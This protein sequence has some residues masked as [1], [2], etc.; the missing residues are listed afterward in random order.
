M[1]FEKCREI[2]LRESELVQEIVG[3]QNLIREAVI[4]RDWTD[5]EGHFDALNRIKTELI[6]LEGER[7]GFLSNSTRFYA[8]AARF[9]HEQR[10]ELTDIYRSLKLETL[11]MQMAGESLM[12]YISEARSTIAGFFEIA[13]PDRGGKMYTPYG[14]PVSH[15]MRSMVLNQAF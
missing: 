15:D 1:V 7:E 3:L 6:A 12:E 11:R 9:P 5:F 8:V 2:L 14:R 13:F 4:G 10:T